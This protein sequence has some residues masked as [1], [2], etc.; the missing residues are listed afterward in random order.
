MWFFFVSVSL[1]WLFYED[2]ISLF[3]Y[4]ESLKKNWMCIRLCGCRAFGCRVYYYAHSLF[5]RTHI[6]IVLSHNE[7]RC[8]SHHCA[9][10]VFGAILT[11]SHVFVRI[12]AREREMV[13]SG[14]EYSSLRHGYT[15]VRASVSVE[16]FNGR[17]IRGSMCACLH[18]DWM[19]L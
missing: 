10:Y 14:N 3:L 1:F 19:C 18:V 6:H 13:W 5:F 11:V 7:S 17:H 16:W 2:S 8:V 9:L 4:S 12:K 15:C